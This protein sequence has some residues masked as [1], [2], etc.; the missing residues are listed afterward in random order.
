MM[1]QDARKPMLTPLE[2]LSMKAQLDRGEPWLLSSG[3]G[4]RIHPGAPDLV[5]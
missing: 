1:N 4:V 3:S 2:A 5:K